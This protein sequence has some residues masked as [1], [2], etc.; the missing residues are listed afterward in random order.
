[1]THSFGGPCLLVFKMPNPS[2]FFSAEEYGENHTKMVIN[3]H[4]YM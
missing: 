2:P 3:D 4:K 1:M